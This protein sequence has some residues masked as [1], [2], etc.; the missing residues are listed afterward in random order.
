MEEIGNGSYDLLPDKATE[1]IRSVKQQFADLF[2]NDEFG[3]FIEEFTAFSDDRWAMLLDLAVGDVA[4]GMTYQG[5][6]W[7]QSNYPYSAPAARRALQLAL[8][9]EMVRH[10]VRSYT[11]IPDTGR[12]GAPDLVRRDYMSRWQSVLSDY[13]QQ[14]KDAC[15]TLD[16]TAYADD[17]ASGNRYKSLID[18]PSAANSYLAWNDAERP[19][20][21]GWW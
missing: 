14:L 20:W 16:A 3:P 2:D 15:K 8:T 21:A 7:T 10:L 4:V 12:V 13:Q 9:I 1:L 18:W 11:E 6:T 5:A 19:M 17:L